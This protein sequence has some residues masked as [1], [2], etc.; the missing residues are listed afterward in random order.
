[1]YIDYLTF[2]YSTNLKLSDIIDAHNANQ[3]GLTYNKKFPLNRGDGHLAVKQRNGIVELQ[4][5][6]VN[7]VYSPNT[8]IYDNTEIDAVLSKIFKTF[9]LEKMNV[10]NMT[11]KEAVDLN[12]LVEFAPSR[13]AF[14]APNENEVEFTDT[15]GMLTFTLVPENEL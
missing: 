6:V 3:T 11:T 10:N 7:A 1:M 8:K 12:A 15:L 9:R 2:E 5:V 13:I 14:V 4:L